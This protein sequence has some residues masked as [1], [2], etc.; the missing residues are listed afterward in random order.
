M[1][2][3]EKVVA[4]GVGHEPFWGFGHTLMGSVFECEGTRERNKMSEKGMKEEQL[5]IVLACESYGL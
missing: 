4:F 5:G 3:G 2:R 1:K